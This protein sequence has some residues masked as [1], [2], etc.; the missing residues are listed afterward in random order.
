[1]LLGKRLE[2][3]ERMNKKWDGIERRRLL[4]NEAES[5]TSRFYPT[6]AAN[7][8]PDNLL[9]ELL[10]HK[11]ELELQNEELR[12]AY[13]AMEE[14]RDRYLDLYEFAPV[15]YITLNREGVVD[16]INLTGSTLFGID[17]SRLV[18]RSFTQFIAPDSQDRWHIVFRKLMA[19]AKGDKQEFPLVL[20]REDGSILYAYLECLRWELVE[21]KP[22]VRVTLT[23]IAKF[24][25]LE[26]A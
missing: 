15:G 25:K 26:S 2:G 24:K 23:D 3:K 22:I 21:T 18:N 5:M 9:H 14:M 7:P 20:L 8:A 11:V 17:R 10:V 16:E 6:E 1:M 12:V 13:F 4:R 19:S